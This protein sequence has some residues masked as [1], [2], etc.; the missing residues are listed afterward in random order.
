MGAVITVVLVFSILWAVPFFKNDDHVTKHTSRLGALIK[1]RNNAKP[2]PTPRKVKPS[3][4][5]IEAP[6]PSLKPLTAYMSNAKRNVLSKPTNV[7]GE[8]EI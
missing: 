5:V 8:L 4:G 7:R 2:A 6:K 1:G 3:F